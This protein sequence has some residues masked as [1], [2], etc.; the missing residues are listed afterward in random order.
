MGKYIDTGLIFDHANANK[1]TVSEYFIYK[2]QSTIIS[3]GTW[4]LDF[5]GKLCAWKLK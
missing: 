3:L 1:F 5:T 4:V 2:V